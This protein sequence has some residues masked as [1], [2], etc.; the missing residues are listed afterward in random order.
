MADITKVTRLF[1]GVARQVDLSVNTLVVDNLKAKLGGA[2]SFTF[3]GSLTADRTIAMPDANV[4]LSH[5]AA[6]VSLSG[7]A[8]GATDLGTFTG[9]T[10]PDSQTIKQALQALETALEG[11][12]VAAGFS[13]AGFNIYDDGDPTK[14]IAF[15]AAGITASTTRTITMP[16]ADVDL[17]N[18]TN[19]N[20]S[21][22]AAIAYS[23]LNLAGSIVNADINTSAAIAESKLALDF[24]TSS[25]NTAIS[26]KVSK[27]GDTMSGN[28]AM[29]GF[30]V[31]GLGAATTNGDAVRY[32]QLQAV[33]ATI[34]GL[35]WQASAFDYITD[36]TADPTANEVTG[37][38]LILSASG[39]A[40]HANYDGASAGDIVEFD[41][42]V[43]VATTPTVGM[44]ISADDE[45]TLLYYWGGSAWTTK[46]FEAT[47]ASGL[48]AKTG[49]D[50]AFATGSASN[51]IVYNA[52]GIA[53]AVAM[54]GE[55]SI[56]DAGAITLS[57]A[58]VIAK[59]LTGFVVGSG[60]ETV[61]ATDSI[62]Q[63]F[64]KLAGNQ[65]EIDANVNDLI[66]LSGV[67]EN[68]TD[69]GIF[70]GST[71]S[72]SN[73]VKGA[74]QELETAHEA[75]IHDASAITYTPSTLSDWNSSS[76]PGQTDDAIDQLAS[77][78]KTVETNVAATESVSEDLVVGEALGITGVRAFRFMKAADAGFVAGRV[79]RADKDAT[80]TDNFHAIGL[81]VALG[82]ESAGDTI[83]VVKGGRITVTAHGFTVGEPLF[84]GA[85]GALIPAGSLANT[86]GEA[87]KQIA[88][89]RDANTLEVQIFQAHVY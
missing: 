55:A 4:D 17:G 79:I 64:Q 1:N 75:H 78:L 22:S 23:K 83:T 8:G 86:S 87:Q 50:I 11:L 5:I 41:G 19:S 89:A 56:S 33:I 37:R 69:L 26:G 74:L 57:N 9:A 81:Y 73:T 45:N 68:A 63:A 24:S 49:F 27:S 38:R 39:G 58:A 88:I 3:S 66:T 36:N 20:I 35:E 29:G 62:L 2:N 59:V 77:R 43:W 51:I 15:Q 60:G 34:N 44:F 85:S 52:S 65:V 32:E 76:D 30:K 67:A 7:V 6:L 18:L 82:T 53:T 84:L 48:L 13:D 42:A 61:A 46:S 80:S 40:P 21:A 47:T 31:T 12:S 28:L 10:I 14:K 16:D 71:I 25:L 54:S 72:D 70:T